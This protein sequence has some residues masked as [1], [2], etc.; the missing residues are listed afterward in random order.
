MNRSDFLV[1]DMLYFHKDV[2][3]VV[4]DYWQNE[5]TFCLTYLIWELVLNILSYLLFG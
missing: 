4:I 1:V 5:N 2:T 3:I